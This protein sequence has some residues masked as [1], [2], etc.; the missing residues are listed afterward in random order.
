MCGISGVYAI[1]INDQHHKLIDAVIKHQ[2]NRGPDHQESIHIKQNHS[3][4]LLGHNRLSIIDLSDQ[5]NQ[6]MWDTSQRFCIV[7]NGEIYNYLELRNELSHLG[8][9]FKT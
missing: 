6:P 4:I 1:H 7:Y 2:F 8:Y 9:S 5:A 3:Q